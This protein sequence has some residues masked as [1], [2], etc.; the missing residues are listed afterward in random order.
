MSGHNGGRR[1]PAGETAR[2]AVHLSM[3]AFALLLRWLTWPTAALCAVAAFAFNLLALPRLVGHRMASGREGAGDTGVL[4]YPL[5]VLGLILL[6][7]RPGAGP[8][9]LAF[10]A[11]GWG[12]LAGGDAAAGI[13]GMKW[14][15]H[16]LPWNRAKSWEGLAGYL[17]GGG[18]I[19]G[20]LLLWNAPGFLEM[21]ALAPQVWP[22]HLAA[23]G[24][25]VLAA[26][27]LESV[28][29]GLD[30][31]VLPPLFGT[32][33]LLT[34]YA[35]HGMLPGQLWSPAVV[36]TLLIAGL[37]NA[38]IAVAS[39]WI[40]LLEPVGVAAAWALGFV[41]WGF[42]SWKA[43]LLLWIFLAVGTIV[44][45]FRR[46]TKRALG[47]ED[48]TRRGVRHVAA[49]GAVCFLGSGLYWLTGG[50]PAAAAMVAAGLAAALADTMASEVGKALGR[51]AYS[52]PSLQPVPPG[53]DGAVSAAGTTAGLIGAGLVAV[54]AAALGFIDPG[55]LAPVLLGGFLAMLA[56]GFL[57]RLGP[58]SN[59]GT[60]LANTVIAVLLALLIRLVIA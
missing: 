20:L 7:H 39:L 60:N 30:D 44:T 48:E 29:H 35:A 37:V 17:A 4:L 53:T 43:Y 12:L 28:P 16:P 5:V 18:A 8:G 31:N 32:Y 15:R 2:K 34:A 49:N 26:A 59:E 25:A 42:G 22:W 11:F 40:G 58:H 27:I 57:P 13:V 1:L 23:V 19:G 33:V 56:E 45:R 55:W 36:E 41:T 52:L 6:F 46:G 38:A 54:P 47:L 9:G 21:L 24:M 14:G 50:A 51:S 3:A 10:V